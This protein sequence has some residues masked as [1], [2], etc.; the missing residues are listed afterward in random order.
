MIGLLSTTPSHTWRARHFGG[1]L[2][3]DSC[4]YY[5][6]NYRHITIIFYYYCYNCNYFTI[7]II[8]III[9]TDNIIEI[10]N[11]ITI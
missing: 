8:I 7:I 10:I 4:E 3:W 11:V 9:I 1:Y 6:K 5:I 2:T